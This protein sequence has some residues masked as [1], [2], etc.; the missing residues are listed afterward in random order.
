MSKLKEIFNSYADSET[1]Y[2]G[3]IMEFIYLSNIADIEKEI[4]K[5]YKPIGNSFGRH[6]LKF[7]GEVPMS[8]VEEII[9]MA[10]EHGL[11]SFPNVRGKSSNL[12]LFAKELSSLIAKER[13]EAVEGF[14]EEM[15]KTELKLSRGLPGNEAFAQGFKSC[16]DRMLKAKELYLSE[17]EGDK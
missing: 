13:K 7:E 14:V 4:L 17:L 12:R 11:V 16:L 15:F 8:G 2:D 3:G 9:D 1:T 6:S 5:H 10:N